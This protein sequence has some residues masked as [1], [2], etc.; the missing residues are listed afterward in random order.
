MMLRDEIIEELALFVSEVDR[1]TSKS[2]YVFYSNNE[3]GFSNG[4]APEN[5]PNEEQVESYILHLRKFL[6]RN[7]RVSVS[8]VNNYVCINFANRR[9]IIKRWNQIFRE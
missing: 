3:V 6:Q 2:F 5:T 1:L 4:T 8:N 7:D 9:D